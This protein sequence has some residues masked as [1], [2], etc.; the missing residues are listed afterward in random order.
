MGRL[1]AELRR[2]DV[3]E[4]TV[5]VIAEH[6]AA[7][8]TTRRIAAEVGCPL[9]TLHYLFHTKEDLFHAVYESLLE[10]AQTLT[11]GQDRKLPLR[12]GVPAHLR[13]LMQWMAA[14]RRFAR[15]Q[16]ELFGWALRFN[17]ELARRT[18]EETLALA[19]SA[20]RQAPDAPDDP[21]LPQ[22]LARL[23]IALIDGLLNAWF[24]HDDI[25]QL[26]AD[27][28]VACRAVSAWIDAWPKA[29]S[30]VRRRRVAAAE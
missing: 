25:D 28:E 15:A 2:R 8:A 9:A 20:L 7:G 16:A 11:A 13:H 10:E 22:A 4:A 29:P 26:G 6:G 24:A 19:R 14:N 12:E 23:L 1:G 21:A 17:P 30:A 5:R 27:T 18:Y 3:V